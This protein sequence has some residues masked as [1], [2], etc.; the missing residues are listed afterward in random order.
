MQQMASA[1]TAMK[2]QQQWLLDAMQ[3]LNEMPQSL[4]EQ[5]TQEEKQPE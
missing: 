1:M 2:G 5:G 3:L 4:F